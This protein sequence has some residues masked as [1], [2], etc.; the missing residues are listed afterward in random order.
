MATGPPAH[1]E[2]P[3]SPPGQSEPGC[4]ARGMQQNQIW[5]QLLELT[6][7]LVEKIIRN[8]FGEWGIFL[9][10]RTKCFNFKNNNMI[11]MKFE[12]LVGNM[13]GKRIAVERLL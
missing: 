9:L 4:I 8:T 3:G 11:L 5:V 13:A 12:K 2:S 7:S 1:R 10:P 6:C